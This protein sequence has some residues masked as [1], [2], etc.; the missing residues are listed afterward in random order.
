[1]AI[2]IV[3]G[4]T[5]LD[6]IFAQIQSGMTPAANTGIEYGAS[7]LDLSSRYAPLSYGSAAAPTGIKYGSSQ[8]DLNTV[9]AAIGTL[10]AHLTVTSSSSSPFNFHTWAVGQI[11]NIDSYGSV[12]ITV[13]SGVELSNCSTGTFTPT[14]KIINNG[15]M[16][17]GGGGGG[18][19]GTASVNLQDPGTAGSAGGDGLNL[20][21]TLTLDN[22][23]G[24][25]WGG[26]GGGGGGGGVKGTDGGAGGGGGGGGQGYPGGPGGAFGNAGGTDGSNGTAG[27]IS[28]PGAGG[29]GGGSD[30]GA[31]SGGNGAAWATAGSYGQSGGAGPGAGGAAGYAIRKNGNTLNLLA[32]GSTKGTI[33]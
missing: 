23:N 10:V 17:G 26:G 33:G 18:K 29:V 22:T 1:M 19:G 2:G 27:T 9:F 20:N 13:N 3:S 21:M 16:Y 5:D 8:D 12:I 4:S 14:L 25:I 15:S 7:K 31:P 32:S 30:G 24:Q 11:S 6:N 28:G